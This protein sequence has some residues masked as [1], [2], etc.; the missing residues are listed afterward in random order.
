MPQTIEIY[1]DGA[2]SPNP[3]PGAYGVILV[4][5]GLNVEL[6]GGFRNTTNN[7]LEMMAAIE[8]LKALNGD[9]AAGITI[10]SDS[11]YLVDMYNGGYARKWQSNGW[12]LASRNPAQNVDLWSVLLEL[13]HSRVKFEWVRGH[14]EHPENERCDA[15]AVAA[16]QQDG[17]PLDPGYKAPSAR[18]AAQLELFGA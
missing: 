15:L 12:R 7:R 3:G 17:L 13:T 18:P 2:C 8:G 11:R 9:R 5:D 1:T 14:D 10:Y 4:R 16:R 6:S